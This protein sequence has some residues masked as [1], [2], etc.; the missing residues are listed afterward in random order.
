MRSSSLRRFA[1]A[2]VIVLAATA[3]SP[4]GDPVVDYFNANPQN[5][6]D[7][8]SIGPDGQPTTPPG[9]DFFASGRRTGDCIEMLKTFLRVGIRYAVLQD[10]TAK[11]FY[12]YQPVGGVRG[13][14]WLTGRTP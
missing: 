6:T 4:S 5:P 11:R 13:Y 2:A 8:F 7:V 12:G 1:I 9:P 10:V 3:Q 14:I